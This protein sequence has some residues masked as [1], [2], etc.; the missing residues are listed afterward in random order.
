[1]LNWKKLISSLLVSF[2]VITL[3]HVWLNIGFSNI[4]GRGANG[5]EPM[6]VG[7]LPV[8]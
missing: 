1:M 2:A 7:F 5:H 6:R 3:L 8:T 4:W